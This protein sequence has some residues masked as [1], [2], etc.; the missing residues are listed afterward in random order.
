MCKV[1][2]TSKFLLSKEVVKG[3]DFLPVTPYAPQYEPEQLYPRSWY[4]DMLALDR[5]ISNL[6]KK[7]NNIVKT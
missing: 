1:I 4:A 2:S 6:I 7:I 3:L 5:E